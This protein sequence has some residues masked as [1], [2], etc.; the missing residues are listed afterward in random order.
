VNV[1]WP[2]SL[3]QTGISVVTLPEERRWPDAVLPSPLT[4]FVGREQDVRQIVDLI[5]Q[6]GVRL[7]TLTGPGGVG[8]T[9]LAIAVAERLRAQ[10]PQTVVFLSLAAITRA[11]LVRTAVTRAFG[12]DEDGS[13]AIAE[14]LAM[15]LGHRAALLVIDNFEHVTSAAP[16]I[17]ELLE[18]CPGLSVLVTSRKLLRLPEEHHVL[19]K[20]L[21]LPDVAAPIA[22]L[23]ANDAVRLFVERAKAAD[24][25][26]SLT[27]EDVRTIARICW[28]LEGL[29]L[30]IELAAARCRILPPPAILSRLSVR[31]SFLGGGP[32]DQ[33]A[34][35][36]TMRDAIAWS[37][38]LLMPAEQALFQCLSVFAGGF[39]MVGAKAVAAKRGLSAGTV[40]RGIG[41]L[42]E[43]SLVFQGGSDKQPRFAMLET[44][45]EYGLEVLDAGNDGELTRASHASFFLGL[46]ERVEAA[47][48]GMAPAGDANLLDSERDNLRAA[49]DWFRERN[50][51]EH[52]LRLAAVLWPHWLEHGRVSEGR[53]Q[54]AELLALPVAPS[55]R[56][57]WTKAAGVA[58]LL[59][60]AQGD[61]AQAVTLSE[62]ALAGSRELGDRRGTATALYTLGLDAMVQGDYDAAERNLQECLALFCTVNDARAGSW[63]LQHLGS[64][65][66]RRG[67]LAQAEAYA[68]EGLALVRAGGSRLDVARLL[69]TL[70]VVVAQRGDSWRAATLWQESLNDFR[71]VGDRW[72]V[73]D[74]LACLGDVARQ[75]GDLIQAKALLEESLSLFREI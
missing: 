21:R 13:S 75:H 47:R 69:H 40:A 43:Q 4:S 56:A 66:Y 23:L 41:A 27:E 22:E 58:G 10:F 29:P 19:V 55:N 72:G 35:L 18:A 57:A 59:A 50:Q 17:T 32:R 2:L 48:I 53:A 20:P 45:R 68:T 14:R 24:P 30:A 38:E 49:L 11:D 64:V 74:A 65:A 34:R 36:R 3:V 52:A 7:V 37:Y 8:K 62:L 42:V 70:G 16:V 5:Q 63:A 28:R 6:E 12:I 39:S 54:L 71:E 25:S 31:M 9:R 67:N 61:H 1:V 51:V 15:M 44:V 26:L 73:A 33:P 46:A 60:Q